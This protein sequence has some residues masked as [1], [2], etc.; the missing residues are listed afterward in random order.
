MEIAVWDLLGNIAG[1]PVH[2]LLGTAVRKEYSVYISD[3]SREGDPIGI[4]ENLLA[5]LK[6]TGAT[7]IKIKV[8]GRMSNSKEN[9]AQTNRYIPALRKILGNNVSIYADA[10]GSYTP[11]E[12]I[13]TGR[14]LE[15]Y[16][17]SIFEEPC[18]FEDEEGMQRVTRSLKNIKVAGGEQDSSAYRF[19]RF[20]ANGIYQILQPDVYY[21]GGIL[22][23]LQVALIAKKYGAN[24]NSSTYAKGRSTH[25]SLLAG[26]SIGA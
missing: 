5:K 19:R 2:H 26:G 10:N 15:Q 11:A 17:I 4:A 20:A 24:R 12:G 16:G 21:N 3:W 8:G 22:K 23:T 14:L 1:V 13:A 6:A 18:N 25:R 9:N 7:G